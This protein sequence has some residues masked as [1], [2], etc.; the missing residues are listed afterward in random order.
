MSTFEVTQVSKVKEFIYS[1]ASCVASI[2]MTTVIIDTNG[3]ERGES[4]EV[5]SVAPTQLEMLGARLGVNSPEYIFVSSLWTP[6]LIAEYI[7]RITPPA[8]LV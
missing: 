6:E 7:A 2:V 5:F 4:T 1:Y 8:E 3:V